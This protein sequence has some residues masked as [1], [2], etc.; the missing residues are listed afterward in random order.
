MEITFV[1]SF[2]Y[3]EQLPISQKPEFAFV[4]RSNVGKSSLINMITGRKNLAHTSGTPGKTQLMNLFD[5]SGKYLIVDLPGYGYARLGKSQRRK[6]E[7]MVRRYLTARTS[8]FLVFLLLDARLKPQLS[9][10]QMLN[11]LGEQKL[12]VALIFTKADKISPTVLAANIKVY[13]ESILSS[14]E[15]VPVSFSTSSQ[16]NIGREEVLSYIAEC[17]VHF[18]G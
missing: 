6:M 18:K 17:L 11:W 14:W 12:P 5:V 4:G 8:L 13:E 1:G 3:L 10:M 15:V 7:G 2:E 16:T 9:D